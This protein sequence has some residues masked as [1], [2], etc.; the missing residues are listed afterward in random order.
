MFLLQKRGVKGS[1]WVPCSFS[2]FVIFL[3]EPVPSPAET[4]SARQTPEKKST[5]L[6][7]NRAM[8]DRFNNHFGERS[9]SHT[10]PHGAPSGR[11]GWAVR[12]THSNSIFSV[13]HRCRIHRRVRTRA[14]L[15]QGGVPGARPWLIR[16]K[17]TDTARP[18][19]DPGT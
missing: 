11:D 12:G 16:A 8:M 3:L 15:S 1:A 4:G 18:D 13:V 10:R 6:D 9:V 14:N 17:Q 7:I 19:S 2:L 5:K